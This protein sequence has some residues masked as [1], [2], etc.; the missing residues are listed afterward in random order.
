MKKILTLVLAA[1]CFVSVLAGCQQDEN[2]SGSNS[3]YKKHFTYTINVMETDKPI[4]ESY[5]ALCEKFNV[6]FDF[7]S[8]TSSDWQEKVR[9]WMAAGD[10]PDVLWANVQNFNY[11]EFVTWAREGL[12]RPM[13][14]LSAYPNVKKT[15]ES[16]ESNKHFIIDGE[17]YAYQSPLIEPE[18]VDR[19][20]NYYTF[21]YRRDWAEQLGLAKDDDTY[22]W[23][24][25]IEIGKGMNTQLDKDGLVGSAGAFP[26][27]AGVMQC[28]PYWEQYVKVGDTYQWGLDLPETLEGIKMAK[29]LYEE[30]VL[31]KDQVIANGNEGVD[32]FKAGEAGICFAQLTPETIQ[33]FYDDMAKAGIPEVEQNVKVMTVKA[34]NG[35][36]WGQEFV[37]YY[38]I[39]CMNPEMD[40]EKYDRLM[41]I[42]DYMLSGTEEVKNLKRYGVEGKDYTIDE[43]GIPQLTVPDSVDPVFGSGLFYNDRAIAFENPSISDAAKEQ[44][45]KVLD[46]HRSEDAILRQYDYDLYF[47]SAP[48]KDKYGLFYEDGRTKMKQIIM[49][50]DDVEGDWE[51]WKA[52]VRDKVDL[53]LEELNTQLK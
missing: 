47:F 31:W 13:G 43:N 51:A 30:G 2:T 35:K 29:R 17:R 53:V 46:M 10:M 25:F 12:L 23:E 41:K 9:I 27:F 11:S 33:V 36:Y 18:G 52:S 40:D 20:Y 16:L 50:S 37:D 1:V 19:N 42:Y 45:Q 5:N 7:I 26:H 3:E 38:S 14:D 39:V 6:E 21:L 24:E 48:N 32:R 15:Q 49:N 28:S 34:P 22:T 4:R 8:F 44:G